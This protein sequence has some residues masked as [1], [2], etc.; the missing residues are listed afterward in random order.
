MVDNKNI[1]LPEISNHWTNLG[2]AHILRH[3]SFAVQLFGNRK[4]NRLIHY[5]DRVAIRYNN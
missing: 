5:D 3:N 4:R 2:T 1:I